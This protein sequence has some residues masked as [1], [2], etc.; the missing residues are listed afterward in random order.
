MSLIGFSIAGPKRIIR[1]SS[2]DSAVVEL[3]ALM[4]YPAATLAEVKKSVG[5][6]WSSSQVIAIGLSS[7]W[8][9]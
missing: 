4:G 1:E 8:E 2:Q 3:F 6:G 5:M 7:E 9:T